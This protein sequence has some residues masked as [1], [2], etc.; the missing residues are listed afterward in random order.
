MSN[1]YPVL[2]SLKSDLIRK[3]S[4]RSDYEDELLKE[5]IQLAGTKLDND[6]LTHSLNVA[7]SVCPTCGKPL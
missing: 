3:G 1:E 6:F 7:S 5:L 2:S 4:N